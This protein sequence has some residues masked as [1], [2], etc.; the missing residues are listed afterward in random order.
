M[1]CRGEDQGT[2]KAFRQWF[3]SIGEL[4]AL[5]SVPIIAL[6]ATASPTAR[7]KIQSS[8]CMPKN[9]TTVIVESPDR[10]NIKLNV[11]CVK[12]TQEE[13]LTFRWLIK[14]LCEQKGAT[15]RHIIFCKSINDCVR[16]NTAFRLSVGKS[17]HFNMYHSHTPENVKEIIKTDFADSSGIIR[18]LICTNSAGMGVNFKGVNNVINYG[19]AQD[20]DTFVQQLGRA[21]R[22]GEDSEH[23]LLYHKKQLRNVE[24]EM[25]TFARN[26]DKCR[27]ELL[28]EYYAV[29]DIQQHDPRCK[30][31]D[32]CALQCECGDCELHPYKQFNLE[33]VE[34]HED[35]LWVRNVTSLQRQ[36]LKESLLTYRESLLDESQSAIVSPDVIHGFTEEVVNQIVDNCKYLFTPDDIM[37]KCS[38]WSFSQ[39][40]H[41]A[42][43]I[44]KLFDEEMQVDDYV[45]PEQ[46]D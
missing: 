20:L 33:S 8:L 12:S 26:T 36:T 3:S 34:E 28:L 4:R 32:V 18:V 17:Q 10:P 41:V 1:F 42:N 39:A 2:T 22:D 46:D 7:K 29:T 19:P 43:L 27:R 37:M 45:L 31:C 6:T 15:T 30:C 16:V 9:K 21:G 35:E 23:L 5:T 40:Q 25:L 14:L 44:T 24:E 11:D 13:E 38:V